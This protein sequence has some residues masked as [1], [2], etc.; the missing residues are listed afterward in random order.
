MISGTINSL[1]R[2]F[3]ARA[4]PL[5][6]S[7]LPY[8]AMASCYHRRGEGD[9]PVV[10]RTPCLCCSVPPP[11]LSSHFSSRYSRFGAISR[12]SFFLVSL[13]W[14]QGILPFQS[15]HALV[16]F[17]YLRLCL[18]PFFL[19]VYFFVSRSPSS[20]MRPFFFSSFSFLH[21]M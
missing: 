7:F 6:G 2:F 18:W 21:T 10:L 20:H 5:L 11:L 13:S 17:L 19:S 12:S 14:I 3:F 1:S 8:L 15:P 4:P 16:S 9:P